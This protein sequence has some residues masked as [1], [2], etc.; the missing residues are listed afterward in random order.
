ML[1]WRKFRCRI[2]AHDWRPTTFEEWL[3]ME[4]TARCSVCG[5]WMWLMNCYSVTP[6]WRLKT[7][8]QDKTAI[9]GEKSNAHTPDDPV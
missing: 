6:N 5:R 3:E 8:R 2:G 7:V 4:A 1:S 9:L